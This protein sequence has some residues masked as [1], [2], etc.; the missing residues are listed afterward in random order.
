MDRAVRK[1]SHQ[2][3][4]PP[5]GGSRFH[6]H[7][8]LHTHSQSIEAI[9]SSRVCGVCVYLRQRCQGRLLHACSGLICVFRE[10][11]CSFGKEECI[12][13]TLQLEAKTA[14]VKPLR[15]PVISSPTEE[16][17]FCWSNQLLFCLILTT[18]TS[19]SVHQC[20]AAV[21]FFIRKSSCTLFFCSH[22]LEICAPS[23]W[24][25]QR[26]PWEQC[27][28][29][30]RMC[31]WKN[32]YFS[33]LMTPSQKCKWPLLPDAAPYRLTAW[34][35][36]SVLIAVFGLEHTVDSLFTSCGFNWSLWMRLHIAAPGKR[37]PKR[38]LCPCGSISYLWMTVLD[39]APFEGIWTAGVLHFYTLKFLWISWIT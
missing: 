3:T 35:L 33:W 31:C 5:S 36:D 2:K 37:F 19:H 30:G 32:L 23:C 29:E 28:I 12:D 10:P 17:A 4:L 25:M 26:H 7:T 22:N 8:R 6:N 18:N 34:R 9:K 11:I 16:N 1:H 14:A 24:G 39:A 15:N 20:R 38:S 13:R 27:C 21:A